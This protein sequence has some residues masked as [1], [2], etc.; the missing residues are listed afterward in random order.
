MTEPPAPEPVDVLLKRVGEW[1]DA[2]YIGP[3]SMQLIDDLAYALYQRDQDAK[4]YA[5]E[6]KNQGGIGEEQG[7]SDD[8]RG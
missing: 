5:A 4:L 6:L 8:H 1:K 2:H 3:F 7:A